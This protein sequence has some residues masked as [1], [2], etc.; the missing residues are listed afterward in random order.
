M[1]KTKNSIPKIWVILNIAICILYSLLCFF[2]ISEIF[3]KVELIEN[4]PV[5]FINALFALSLFFIFALYPIRYFCKLFPLLKKNKTE[6]VT[7][8]KYRMG[9]IMFFT[10]LVSMFSNISFFVAIPF[11]ENSTTYYLIPSITL[12]TIA[13]LLAVILFEYSFHKIRKASNYPIYKFILANG[14]TPNEI[15]KNEFGEFIYSNELPPTYSMRPA[16][17]RDSS[18]PKEEKEKL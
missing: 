12:S 10:I 1:T 11:S 17:L 18:K 13:F 16:A 2:A 4:D 8:K 7:I 6:L 14:D 15:L 9:S 3:D 5:L